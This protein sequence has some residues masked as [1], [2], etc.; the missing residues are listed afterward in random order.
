[1][2]LTVRV[3]TLNP[4]RRASARALRIVHALSPG[5]YG[6]L[7][8]VVE[9]LSTAQQKA[10]HDVHVVPSVGRTHDHPFVAALRRRNVPVSAITVPLRS[11][12]RERAELR[13]LLTRLTPDIV[14]THGYRTDVLAAGVVRGL[15]VCAVST[16]HGFAGGDAKNRLYEWLEI[17][18]YRSLDAVVA[19]S[20]PLAARL[21]AAGIPSERVHCIRNAWA[22]EQPLLERAEARVRLGLPSEGQVIGWVGRLSREKGADVMIDALS[23]MPDGTA[24]LAVVG[25]GPERE[26]LKAQAER[27]GVANRV[28][29]LGVFP[30]VGHLFAAFDWFA[31][32]SRTEGTPIVLFEAM[33]AGIPIVATAVGGVPEVISAEEG[34]LVP[35][36]DPIALAQ[37][38]QVV[39]ADR[40]G[41]SARADSA[42]RRLETEFSVT[43]WVEAYDG[44]YRRALT[45]RGMSG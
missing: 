15:N 19:V 17:R 39:L 42:R 37:A 29:W 8:R 5:P 16:A 31:L 6:G 44:V 18:A 24:Q 38:L 33:A 4:T 32:S 41:A 28:Y 34:L 45:D 2:T 40:M 23:L 12:L 14:H 3:Q 26:A 10:G 25:G 22:S 7:E 27:L 43:R 21:R 9:M 35:S 20:R 30:E 1:M 11:Y 13:R 36:E